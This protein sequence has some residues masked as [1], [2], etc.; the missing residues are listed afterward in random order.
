MRLNVLKKQFGTTESNSNATRR[1]L[2]E[3]TSPAREPTALVENVQQTQPETPQL[4]QQADSSVPN[5]SA[6]NE[7]MEML[8]AQV[9]E[10]KKTVAKLREQ[11]DE[12]LY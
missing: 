6:L 5:S 8:E 4:D 7:R 11:L 2:L 10:L 3:N 1:P 12:L 9:G